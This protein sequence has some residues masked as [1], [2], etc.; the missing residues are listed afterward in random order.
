MAKSV[1]T[2]SDI[3][4]K[5]EKL[6]TFLMGFLWEFKTVQALAN[7]ELAVFKRFPDKEEMLKTFRNFKNEIVYTYKQLSE[8]DQKEFE[9]AADALGQAIEDYEDTGCELYGV[10]EYVDTPEEEVAAS[11]DIGSPEEKHKF[12]IG[13]IKKT[14]A[15][16][17]ALQEEAA[18]TLSNPFANNEEE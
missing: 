7:L 8:E 14:T 18:N 9:E 12:E 5:Y 3:Q 4:A 10:E 16:E 15:E 2:S 1:I 11:E 13:D 17:K 6:Y